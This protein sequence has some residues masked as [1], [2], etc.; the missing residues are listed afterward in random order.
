MKVACRPILAVAILFC[1]AAPSV[2]AQYAHTKGVEILDGANHPIQLKGTNLG[3][4]L[5]PEGYMW[6]FD[7]GPQSPKEI[8]AFLTELVG[9]TR[10]DEFWKTYRDRYVTRDDIRFIRAQGFNMVR[11]P[12]HWKLFQTD[13]AEGFRLLDRVVQW[14]QEAGLYV[15]LD[16]HA[17]PGGQTGTNIDDGHGYPWLLRDAGAQQQTIDLWTRLARH[18]R[19]QPAVLGYDLLNEPIPNYPGYEVLHPAL[20]PLYKRI[21]TA[22][23]SVDRNHILILGGAEWDGDFSVFGPPF[24]SNTIYQL[25]KYWTGVNQSTLEP[26]IAYRDKYH[27]PIWLGESGENTDEWVT[28]F[29]TLLDTN[30]IGW[31]FWPYKKMQVTS[32]PVSFAPPAGW[33]QI[34]AYAKLPRGDGSVKERL[35]ER[36]PQT[37]ID[38]ALAGLLENIEFEKCTVNAGYIHALLPDAPTQP[39]GH[40]P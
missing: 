32:A 3:N 22:I 21:A 9:P 12:L 20:E 37:V 8:E 17:A 11:V 27:V 31:A 28:H 23:R 14:S 29:R 13:D 7:G 6:R 16:L 34:V 5:V 25:H 33:D 39:T 15:I 36:P 24:D 4:W 19:N 35:K 30:S 26:F 1:F 38:A 2:L 40:T 18:Y 10:A